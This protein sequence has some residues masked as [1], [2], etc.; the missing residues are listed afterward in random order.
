MWFVFCND[1]SQHI[2]CIGLPTKLKLQLHIGPLDDTMKKETILKDREKLLEFAPDIANYNSVF[3]ALNRRWNSAITA[4]LIEAGRMDH[5]AAQLFGPLIQDM[6]HTKELYGQTQKHLVDAILVEMSKKIVSQIVDTAAFTIN[7]LKRNLFE[8][9]ADVGYLATDSE[10]VHFLK[11][12]PDDNRRSSEARENIQTRLAEYQYEYTVYNDILILDTQGRVLA[13]MDETNRVTRSK[14]PLLRQTLEIDPHKEDQYLETYGET[15]LF[16][17]LGK[18]LIYSQK[19]NDPE[20]SAPLGVLCLCFNLK[21]EADRIFKDLSQ[22]NS[23]IISAVLDGNGQVMFSS[24]RDLPEGTCI[25]VDTNADFRLMN[26]NGNTSFVTTVPTSGYQGFYGLTWYG[27]AMIP[28]RVAFST[29]ETG[30][31]GQDSD[32]LQDLNHLSKDLTSLRKQSF[33]LLGAM[34]IDSINGEVQAAKF[35]ALAFVKVLH[36]VK[37]IGEDIDGLFS[38]AIENL[39]QTVA[40]SLFSDVEF[41]AFQGNNIADRNLYERANDVCWWA[42]T[43]LFRTLL[44]KHKKEGLTSQD[45][46]ALQTNLQYINNLYTPYLRLVLADTGGTILAVSNPPGEL[47]ERVLDETLPTGQE[48][49][50]TQAD[51]GLVHKAM[52]LASS[53]DYRVSDFAPSPLYGGRHTYI[54]T[55][56]VRDPEDHTRPVGVIQIVF[57]SEPQ[58]A[59]MLDDILPRDETNA[60][61]PG[62]FAVFADRNKQVIST[63]DPAFPVGSS[64]PFEDRLF[65]HK[66][67]EREATLVHIDEKSYALGLQVSSGYREYKTGDG[68]DN[69]VICMVLVPV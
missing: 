45:N 42:L 12:P 32:R 66:K 56:A 7:I 10:I 11:Q 38:E 58:F 3:K 47:E 25:P 27:M 17:G 1:F 43:P 9:T 44:A 59:A 54:Y 68:Y 4:G 18:K 46:R 8:R 19:I 67:G 65:A 13:A 62:S 2:F 53:K 64:L 69:D 57:D 31:N 23:S 48:F 37:D 60:V 6:R 39:Q 24:S 41:R 15:D 61:V 21:D 16:P 26:L 49:I 51:S 22:G 29:N 40:T 20:T 28:T 36:F 55:T 35:R 52:A 5:D 34:K 33:D 14:T 63:T 30:S 50:G